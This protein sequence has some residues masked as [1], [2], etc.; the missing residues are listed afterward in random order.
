[1]KIPIYQVDAFAAAVFGGNRAPVCRLASCLVVDLMQKIARKNNL[2]KT[3]F[4]VKEKDQYSIRWFT[5]TVEVDLCG[6]ATL[7]S[8]HVLF[9]HL[10]HAGN[11]IKFNSNRSGCLMVKKSGP[12][13][14][15][16]FPT[17][18]FEK[19]PVPIIAE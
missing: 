9:E 12:I 17:D 2:L 15:L 16:D 19:I 3:P 8:A 5:P 14:T 4:F 18:V 13:L 6:H 7:A 1:M 11:E 10:E